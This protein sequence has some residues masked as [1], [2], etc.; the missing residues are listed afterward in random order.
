[1]AA[2]KTCESSYKAKLPLPSN[3]QEALDFYAAIQK[4]GNPGYGQT[5]IKSAFLD[6]S[7]AAK[8]GDWRDSQNNKIT[9]LNWHSQEPV[10][11]DNYLGAE[12]YLHIQKAWNGSWNDVLSSYLDFVICQKDPLG[13]YLTMVASTNGNVVPRG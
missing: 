8:E 13:K 12:N 1:M 2:K 3:T 11:P 6:G 7:D 4:M 9:Y 5:K 10:Q